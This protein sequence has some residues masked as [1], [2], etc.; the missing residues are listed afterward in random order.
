MDSS[1]SQ[2]KQRIYLWDN[3]KIVL[4]LFVV[5]HHASAP[6]GLLEGQRWY[7]LLLMIIMPYTM[8]A[9]TI[10]SGYWFKSR[11][12]NVLARKFLLPALLVLFLCYGLWPY[13]RYYDGK[14]CPWTLDIMWYLWVLFFYYLITPKL[15]KY[16]LNIILIA[17][18][19]LSLFA[20]FFSCIGVSFSLGR[21]IG[22]YPFFLLGIKIRLS[23]KWSVLSESK[24]AIT[25]ARI[26]FAVTLI[27]Y[28]VLFLYDNTL[29]S[30]ISFSNKY[31]QKWLSAT[32]RL[33]TYL[34]C[35]VLSLSLILSMPNKKYRFTKY[36]SRSLTPYLFHPLFLYSL[37]WRYAIPIMNEWYGYFFYMLVIPALSMMTVHSKIDG[38]VKKLTS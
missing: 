10:I 11:P 15:L 24:K 17:S 29:S 19:L 27:F 25:I 13:S 14:Y 26:V 7:K 22:F 37:S 5:I 1:L 30:Y 20:G 21:M 23:A 32:Y 3:L 36:G 31:D 35:T 38:L 6:Y 9:F 28:F 12:V 18:V 4:I 34:I 8:S 16:N 2:N 33:F